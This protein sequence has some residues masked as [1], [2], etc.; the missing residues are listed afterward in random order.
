MSRPCPFCSQTHDGPCPKLA[1]AKA[2]KLASTAV[3]SAAR[4]EALSAPSTRQPAPP[5]TIKPQPSAPRVQAPCQE[6]IRLGAD[7][8][9]LQLELATL[10]AAQADRQRAYRARQ[11]ERRS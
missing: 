6:C 8:A 4:R 2:A 5:P 1:V 3:A 10:R 11:K 7:L 9:A